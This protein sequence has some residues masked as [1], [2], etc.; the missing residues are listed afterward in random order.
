[1]HRLANATQKLILIHDQK[2]SSKRFSADASDWGKTL[3]GK[4]YLQPYSS[5]E[6]QGAACRE[7]EKS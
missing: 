5:Q 4:A 6:L 2:S 3:V 1:M 7:Q